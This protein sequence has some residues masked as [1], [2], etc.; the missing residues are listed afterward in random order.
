M[1]S[2]HTECTLNSVVCKKKKNDVFQLHCQSALN[3]VF[4]N[5]H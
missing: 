5:H 4:I 1:P 2:L 3:D